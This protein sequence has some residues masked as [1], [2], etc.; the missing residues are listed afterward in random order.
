[1]LALAM[2][3]GSSLFWGLS[4]YLGGVRSRIFP[5]PVVLAMMYGSSL[6]VMAVFIAVRGEGPPGSEPIVAGLCSGLFGIAALA[7]FYRALAIGTMSIVAPIASTGVAL[8]VLVG[9]ATG[10]QPGALRSAGLAAAVVGVILAS[11]EHHDDAAAGTAD[12]RVRRQSIVLAVIAGFG[13]GM[14]FV[15]AEVASSGDVGWALLL[16]RIAATPFVVAFTIRTLRRGGRRPHG[17][18]YLALVVIGM[19]DLVANVLYNQATTIGELS[20]VA[21]ASSLYPVM[22][23]LLAAALLGER[24]RGMQRVG[25]VVALSGVVLIAAGA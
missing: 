21:V 18:E 3:L 2:A 10:D 8:P 9:L 14:Y 12:P 6:V 23:V 16:S 13:F 22:T 5:V 7:C 4:D 11:R 1:M 25:V 24:V 19:L 15:L 17:S 20:T